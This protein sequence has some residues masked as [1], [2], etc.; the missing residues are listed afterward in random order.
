MRI[1]MNIT[2]YHYTKP[3]HTDDGLFVMKKCRVFK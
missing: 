1:L 2:K 3:Y